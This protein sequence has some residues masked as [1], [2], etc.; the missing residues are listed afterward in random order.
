M[1]APLGEPLAREPR[2]PV[3]RLRWLAHASNQICDALL[4]S[5]AAGA[6]AEV[7]AL[8]KRYARTLGVS[9]AQVEHAATVAQQ[10]L[11]QTAKAMNLQ[12]SANSPARRLLQGA[13]PAADAAD[14]ATLVLQPDS[15]VPHSLRA[16]VAARAPQPGV[17]ADTASELLASGIQDITNSMVESFKLNDV[18]RMILET[19]Y[20][21][22]GF[23]R[24]VFCLRDPKTETLTGRFGLGEDAAAVAARFRV[25]LKT[26]ADLFSAVCSK[27]ADTLIADATVGHIAAR[28]PPWYRDHVAAPAFLL[29]PM[30]LKGAAFALIYA[31]KSSAGELELGD[32]EL[33]LLRTLR[34]QAVMAFKQS[35]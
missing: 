24:V 33:S 2:D 35:A 9:A 16:T 6:P 4:R 18:L 30:T 34:N 10:R 23:R 1:R 3:E 5:D 14:A 22:L 12:V 17:P 21:A 32:K 29:L 28:L 27:G 31:D 11:A 7:A 13:A 15:L 20:R 25:P 19:M 26:G 8:A